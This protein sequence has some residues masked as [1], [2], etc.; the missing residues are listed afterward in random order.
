MRDYQRIKK[1]K[2]IL[3]TTVYNKTIWTIRDYYRLKERAEDYLTIS[4]IQNDKEK[5]SPTNKIE[6]MVANAAIKREEFINIV[7]V[8]DKSIKSIPME[9]QKGIW[10]N[11]IAQ[12]PYPQDANKSTYGRYKSKFIFKVAEKLRYI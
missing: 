6:D 10:N 9:Y 5:V 8:I 1:N 3:P 11:I 2:Y 4:S 7:N 12:R